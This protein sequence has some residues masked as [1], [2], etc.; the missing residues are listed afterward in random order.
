MS[1]I[2][3]TSP[4]HRLEEVLFDVKETPVFTKV[5]LLENHKNI[6]Q[7]IESGKHKALLNDQTKQL[8]SIVSKNYQVITNQQALDLGKDIFSD[9]FASVKKEELIPYKVVATKNL[10]TCH[11]DLIHKETK[12]EIWEQ[13]TWLPFLRVSNSFNRSYALTYEFGFVRKLCSNGF[14]FNKK[15]IKFKYSHTKKGLFG[16]Y[17]IDTSSLRNYERQFAGYRQNLHRFY[18]DQKYV[19]PIVLKSLNLKF[20][21]IDNPQNRKEEREYFKYLKAKD[22]IKNLTNQYYKE[23][24]P[25]AYAVLNIMTD[26]VS[27]QQEILPFYSTHINGY[28]KKPAYWMDSFIQEVKKDNFNMEEYLG[29]F[30]VYLN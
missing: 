26:L 4:S 2:D 16:I 22:I 9:A 20:K 5:N 21:V 7:T 23:L 29:E 18:V 14:I 25:T 19:L 13:D 17:D 28:Y 6:Y 1:A 24:Q 8:L 27:H 12:L 15:T 10:T 3:F 11:I 30:K